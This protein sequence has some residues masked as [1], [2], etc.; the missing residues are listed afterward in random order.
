MNQAKLALLRHAL[1]F[2]GGTLVSKGLMDEGV[3]NELVG[4]IISITSISWM[5]FE[6]IKLKKN[7]PTV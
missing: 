7:E 5:I 3:L 4:A 2:L 6:K 1:T